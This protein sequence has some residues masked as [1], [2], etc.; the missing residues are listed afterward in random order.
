[1]SKLLIMFLC[2]LVLLS[3]PLKSAGKV[4]PDEFDI[5]TEL[6]EFEIEEEDDDEFELF[7]FPSWNDPS[8]NKIVVNVDSFGAVGDGVADDTQA[9]VNA[10]KQACPIQKSVMLVPK[11]KTYLVKATTFNGPCA[12]KFVV[13]IEGTI[14]APSDPETWD[15]TSPRTWLVFNNLTRFVIQGLGVVEGSGAKWWANSC[16][17]NKSNPCISAPTALTIDSSSAVKMKGLTIQN[18][19]QM[20]VI[21]ARS[22]VV[23]LMG[24]KV[25]APASSPN[26]DGIHL[27]SSTNVVLQNCKIGTGDDCISIVNGCSNI[28]MK[29]IYCGPGHGIS[30]GSLGNNNSTAKVEGIVLDNGYLN[31]TNNGLRLKTYQGGT[32]YAKAIRFQNVHMEN[33]ANPVIIDQFYCDSKTKCPIMPSAVQISQIMYRNITGTS[34]SKNVMKFACSDTIP[35]TNIILSNISLKSID[36][37]AETY[38]NSASGIT[39]GSIQPSADCLLSSSDKAAAKIILQENEAEHVIHTEL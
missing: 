37:P 8:P 36:G 29:N 23:R 24:V 5:L 18:G 35:C 25:S 19:Q 1:M 26:T 12:P 31:N 34:P 33:V 17:K 27:T 7:D 32:G 3:F 28:K 10:W 14:V 38:C 39:R 22:S 21:V 4:F 13:Q 15:P 16:K 11:S 2:F 6:E 30:I 20:N 9:F